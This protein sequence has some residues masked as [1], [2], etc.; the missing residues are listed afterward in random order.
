MSDLSRRDEPVPA[1]RQG[2]IYLY[3]KWWYQTKKERTLI[4]NSPLP[5]KGIE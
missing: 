3:L 1:Y 4:D 5:V 2:F